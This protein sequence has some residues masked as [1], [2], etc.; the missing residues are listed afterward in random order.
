M[1][2]TG[3][4]FLHFPESRGFPARGIVA[5]NRIEAAYLASFKLD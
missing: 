1:G 2:G 3:G 4:N 5:D